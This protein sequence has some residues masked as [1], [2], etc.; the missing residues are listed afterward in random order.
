MDTKDSVIVSSPIFKKL[1]VPSGVSPLG[2]LFEVGEISGNVGGERRMAPRRYP[3]YAI[4]VIT[5]LE[6]EGYY[7][8]LCG[9]RAT[10]HAGDCIL[11]HP[12]R[13]HSYGPVKGAVW[14]EY[15]ISFDGPVFDAL[16]R[17]GLLS[18]QHPPV[19]PDAGTR[20]F[21]A[22]LRRIADAGEGGA[23]SMSVAVGRLIA[24]LTELAERRAPV[25]EAGR[26]DWIVRA[27][28][29]LEADGSSVS[30]VCDRFAAAMAMSP[31]ALRKRFRRETGESMEARRLRVRLI[32]A[33]ELI[34]RTD[35]PFKTLADRL[36]FTHEQHFT[37]TIRA[38]TG[39]SPGRLRAR[40]GFG[41]GRRG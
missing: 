36:G 28:E 40:C 30:E 10:L 16:D 27:G 26:Q 24:L 32:R 3:G 1:S 35:L 33:V 14:S 20:T 38:A 5:A 7:E 29:A 18:R 13:M 37:R 31:D 2:R 11:V 25:A 8:D 23:P 15:Y 22:R 6:G 17:M 41:E 19:F 34:E 4:V 39:F 12:E 9:F 21:S